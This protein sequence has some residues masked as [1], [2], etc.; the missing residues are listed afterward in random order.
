MC[1]LLHTRQVPDLQFCNVCPVCRQLVQSA[2]FLT[3]FSRSWIG[4]DRKC[5]QRL[6]SCP[7]WQIGHCKFV[8]KTCPLVVS[9]LRG[10]VVLSV[11]ADAQFAR[12]SRKSRRSRYGS[13]SLSFRVNSQF[14]MML[15]LIL[16]V[17][18]VTSILFQDVIG[19][20][21]FRSAH[22]C[23]LNSATNSP[24]LVGQSSFIFG[25]LWRASQRRSKI[26][27]LQLNFRFSISIALA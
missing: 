12:F 16:D 18:I 13:I 15:G 17:M 3:L 7:L 19:S 27:L 6:I 1:R 23:W 9:L 21:R 20:P 4:W 11:A 8:K 5:W 26:R 10:L 22:R 25:K 24:I 14:Q 2:A